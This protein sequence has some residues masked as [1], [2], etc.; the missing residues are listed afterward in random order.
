MVFFIFY[1]LKI[2]QDLGGGF[3]GKIRLGGGFS[4]FAYEPLRI[5]NSLKKHPKSTDLGAFNE[6]KNVR[7]ANPIT[8]NY[9]FKMDLLEADI[10]NMPE[11]TGAN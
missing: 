3:L 1:I 5:I 6:P 4:K 8:E 11:F 9:L 7:N 2:S 10:H